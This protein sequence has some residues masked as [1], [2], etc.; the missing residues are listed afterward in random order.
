MCDII[1]L[2]RAL[3]TAF[4]VHGGFIMTKRTGVPALMQVALRMC[5]LIA[6]FTPVI[7]RLYGDNAA[8]MAA[9]AAAN[10]ACAALHAELATVREYGV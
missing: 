6:T 2:R 4:F 8:L 5:Q 7:E 3:C 9:L 1:F 10:T